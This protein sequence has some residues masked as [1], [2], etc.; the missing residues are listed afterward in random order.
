[1]N[2]LIEKYA[3]GPK[4]YSVVIRGAEEHFRG[5]ILVSSAEGGARGGDVLCS[6]SKVAKLNVKMSI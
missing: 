2:Q 6:P 5:H 3:Q 4:I 1:M